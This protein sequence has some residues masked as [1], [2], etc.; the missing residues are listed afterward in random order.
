MILKWDYQKR[1]SD[2]SMPGYVT[3]V[4]NT[5]QHD[6]PTHP[7]HTHHPSVTPIYG[8]KTQ[9]TTRDE[10]PLLSTNQCTNIQKITGSVLYYA[11]AVYPTV[12]M[13]INDIAT[14]QTKATEKT[15][16]AANQLLDYL[17][18]HPDATIRYHKSDM[19]L[20]IH[21]DAS[22]LSISHAR[23][24]LGGLFYCRN[25][26]P[27]ADKLNGSILNAAAVI[28]NIVASAAKSEVGA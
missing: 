7:Q 15:Q 19:T 18:T 22:Y 17:A 24:R 9:Y 27:Q 20:H 3:Y 13:P 11:R 2:I 5:F 21:S 10:T 4:L 6:A 1:T 14:E 16:A 12:P 23:S 26:P 28:K 8:A 25:K